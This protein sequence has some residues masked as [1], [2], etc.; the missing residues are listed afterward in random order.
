[1][2]DGKRYRTID[3]TFG[4]EFNVRRTLFV[5]SV[6]ILSG[7]F[8]RQT[9]S[10]RAQLAVVG[11]TIHTSPSEE[12]IRNGVVLVDGAKIVAVGRRSSVRVPPGTNVIDAAG[13]T[14][15]AGFWN[16]H[17][18]FLEECGWIPPRSPHPT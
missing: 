6:V 16:S 11:A 9:P 2:R 4:E 15:T 17:V 12:P 7:F 10:T 18:H 13:S 5:L 14:M 8:P 3:A 1:L